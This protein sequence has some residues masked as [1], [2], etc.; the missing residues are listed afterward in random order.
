MIW[1]L[2]Q[3]ERTEGID[4]CVVFLDIAYVFG[5]VPQSDSVVG[6]GRLVA[7]RSPGRFLALAKPDCVDALL[8][9]DNTLYVGRFHFI[10]S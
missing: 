10:S 4:L 1:H 2:M 8:P 7:H 6:G 3:A 5:Y 9:S